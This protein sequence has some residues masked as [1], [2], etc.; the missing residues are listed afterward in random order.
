MRPDENENIEQEIERFEQEMPADTGGEEPPVK[1]GEKLK[2]KIGDL[3]VEID[4]E[5]ST[6]SGE[7][8]PGS[9]SKEQ[10]AT[11]KYA[12]MDREQLLAE[13]AKKDTHI[14]KLSQQKKGEESLPD[15]NTSEGLKIEKQKAVT[16]MEKVKSE[17]EELDP[18]MDADKYAETQKRLDKLT[19]D[20]SDYDSKIQDKIVDERIAAKLDAEFNNEFVAKTRES[21]K[22]DLGLEFEDDAWEKIVSDA[23][24]LTG[25]SKMTPEAM[26]AAMIQ[27]IGRDKYRAVLS[28]IA[29]QKARGDIAK[30][31]SNSIKV[32][33]ESGG[34][35]KVSELSDYQKS[36]ILDKVPAEKLEELAEQL[37]F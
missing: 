31:E 15:A 2:V 34:F 16:E 36:Q 1:A 10:S 18:V 11:A 12:K 5:E 26:E 30:A 21:Y 7:E 25:I 17:L 19:K 37:G 24:S 28:A 6:G 13:L 33:T 22:S 20:I 27:N 4:S 32:I 29:E 35:R 14:T 23:K 3:E 8:Q 9:D